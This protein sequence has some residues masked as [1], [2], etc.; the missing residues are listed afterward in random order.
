MKQTLALICPIGSVSG[1]GVHSRLIAKALISNDAYDVKI[2][3]TKWGTTP[4]NGLVNGQDDDIIRRVVPSLNF[5]PDISIQITIPSEAQKIGKKSILITAGTESSICSPEFI[6][7]CNRVDLVIVPSEFTKRVLQE[8]QIEKRNNQ[9]NQVIETMKVNTPIEVCFEGIDVKL[10]DKNTIEYCPDVIDSLDIVPEKFCFLFVGTWLQGNLGHDRK[11]VGMLIKTFIE[12]FKR[13]ASQNK[14]ALIL[15]THGAGYSV[16]EREQI[17]DKIQQIQQMIRD[18][19]GYKGDFPKIYL[20]NG[21]LSD[22]EMN[23]L[24]NHPKIKAMVSFTKAEGFGLPFLEFQTTGKPLIVSNY[25]GHLDFVN[26]DFSQLLPGKLTNIDG[27]AANEWIVKQGQWFTVN[28]QFAG[29]ILNDMIEHYDKY[30]EKSR[31]T[32]K[33]VKDNWSLEKMSEKLFGMLEKNS[34]IVENKTERPVIHL[35]KLKKI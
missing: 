15:K 28:Y 19:S 26:K 6:D 32:V 18:V 17:I 24:Y 33:W 30:L 1:Y 31:K 10:F 13:K 3:S 20:L 14:P 9:T 8:T 2:I 11:D 4:L 29:E 27:S 22:Y 35:P 21:E 23:A 16:V 5:Q 34:Y 25:S 12:V 7:G